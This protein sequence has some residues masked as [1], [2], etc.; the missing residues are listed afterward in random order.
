M[1]A[2][3]G[4]LKASA[5][6]T[7]NPRLRKQDFEWFDVC[8]TR[9]FNLQVQHT[10]NRS[11]WLQRPSTMRLGLAL[12]SSRLGRLGNWPARRLVSSSVARAKHQCGVV[13]STKR[14][15]SEMKR[16]LLL[17]AYLLFAALFSNSSYAGACDWKLS[18]GAMGP[19]KTGM[20]LPQAEAAIGMSLEL[21]SS[22]ETDFYYV[23]R[24]CKTSFMVVASTYNTDEK[25]S[26]LVVMIVAGKA[27]TVDGLRVADSEVRLRSLT[28]TYGSRLSR[29]MHDHYESTINAYVVAAA[30]READGK[31]L[32]YFAPHGTIS[33]VVAGSV[34]HVFRAD[35]QRPEGKWWAD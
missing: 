23:P 22:D 19:L 2:A 16:A 15:A 35:L 9:G 20:S 10:R 24:L 11:C 13:R 30:D 3:T 14:L 5:A 27:P 25:G 18:P 7:D 4:T 31:V 28:A 1:I 17:Q 6:T 32:V 12:C 26:L 21:Q 33:S 34:K 8:S 29:K